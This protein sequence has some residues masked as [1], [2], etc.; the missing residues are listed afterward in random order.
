M[1]TSAPSA[2]RRTAMPRPMPLLLPVTSTLRPSRRP[3][4]V[5]AGAVSVELFIPAI[6]SFNV[7]RRCSIR[8]F[9]MPAAVDPNRLAGDEIGLAQEHDRLGNLRLA[10]PVADRC[11]HRHFSDLF[12]AHVGR[13][14]NR[15]R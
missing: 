5:P 14:H 2:A 6:L 15:T 13:R 10:A 9:K 8:L 7:D 11:G 12:S 1:T 3:P 4:M